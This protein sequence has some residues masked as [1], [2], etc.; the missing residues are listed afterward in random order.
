V[1]EKEQLSLGLEHVFKKP[2]KEEKELQETIQ[3]G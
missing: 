2:G 1:I 3:P